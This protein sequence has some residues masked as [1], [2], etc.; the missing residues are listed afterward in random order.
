VM[1]YLYFEVLSFDIPYDPSC[2]DASWFNDVLAASSLCMKLS[3]LIE[4]TSHQDV[5]SGI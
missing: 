4:P 5:G 2:E 3:G 1:G